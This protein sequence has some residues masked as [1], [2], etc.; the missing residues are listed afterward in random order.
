MIQLYHTLR[1]GGGQHY[2]VLGADCWSPHSPLAVKAVQPLPYCNSPKPRATLPK[3]ASCFDLLIDLG[4]PLFPAH[5][6]TNRSRKTPGVSQDSKPRTL[7][8]SEG[9]M[10]RR[11]RALRDPGD[12]PLEVQNIHSPSLFYHG[13]SS[14]CFVCP[15]PPSLATNEYCIILMKFTECWGAPTHS[16]RVYRT[17]R[18][19]RI[20]ASP[21]VL[22][23][24]ACLAVRKE[25]KAPL[26]TG[27]LNFIFSDEGSYHR[28]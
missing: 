20:D 23:F 25:F 21:G 14:F 7:H 5:L 13:C 11:K 1:D 28:E 12:Q 16:T 2:R 26:R 17:H 4:V 24:W 3:Y 8:E 22:F 9:T 15:W 19:R 27:M 10:A 6:E 18:T